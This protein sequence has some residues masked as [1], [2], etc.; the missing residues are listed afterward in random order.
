MLCEGRLLY[1]DVRDKNKLRKCDMIPTDTVQCN[2]KFK[3][4]SVYS[5][6][7]FRAG[8]IVEVCPVRSIPKTA[9]YSREVRDMAFEAVPGEEYVIPYGYCQFYDI[10]DRRHP[11]ANCIA[12]WNPRTRC[13][14]IRADRDIDK[15][16]VLVLQK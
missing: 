1:G 12:E 6:C 8:E 16:E 15:D 10:V 13:V 5:K 11:E 9:L 2:V 14:I 7:K 4:K 3:A